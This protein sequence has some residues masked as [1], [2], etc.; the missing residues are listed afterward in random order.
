MPVSSDPGAGKVTPSNNPPGDSTHSAGTLIVVTG[1]DEAKVFLNGKLQ[2]QLTRAGQLRLPN[3]EPKDYVVQVSKPGFQDPPQQ[4]IHIQNG[5]QASLNFNLQPQPRLASLT[6]QGGA[7]GTTVLVDQTPIG[8]IQPDGTLS[9]S[10]VNPGDHTVELRKERFKPRQFKKHFVGGGT[11]S[12][13]AADA[14]LEA[15]PSALKITFAPADASVAIVKGDFLKVVS[16]GVPLSVAPGTYTLTARTADRF[17]RSST[18]EVLPGQSKSLDLSLAPSGMSKWDDPSSWKHEGDSFTRRGGD[19][20]LYGAAPTSGTF[21]FSAI[22]TKGR[23]LQW[24]LNYSDPKNY[25]LFQMDDNNFYRSVIHN[26][27]KTDQIIVPHKV[28]KKSFRTIQIRVSP[29]EIIH[30]IKT[31]DRWTV[32][33]HWTQPGI[34]LT[35]GK[36]GFYIPGNDQVAL[37]SFAHYADLNIH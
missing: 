29:T 14:A 18:F 27:E 2:R 6:I 25:V 19:F 17:T 35:L 31:G 8:T 15:A 5:E 13:A 10:S 37:S 23:V 1:Q 3:L 26:G 24:V 4:K 21:V 12:L 16:T 9:V 11:I 34:N 28:D 20:V 36:F 30:E 22:A 7:P 32:L 33:D